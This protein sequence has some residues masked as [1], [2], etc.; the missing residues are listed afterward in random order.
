MQVGLRYLVQQG[1]V[2]IPRTNNPERLKENAAI[3]DFELSKAEMDEI[4]ALASA[5]GR[6]VSVSWAPDWD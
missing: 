2:I 5:K 3:F 1:F 4:R 6:V